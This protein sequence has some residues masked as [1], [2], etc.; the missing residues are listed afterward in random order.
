MKAKIDRQDVLLPYAPSGQY[1]YLI[2]AWI[3]GLHW[4]LGEPDVLASFRRETGNCWSSGRGIN[5]MI[6]EATG[7]DAEFIKQFAAWFNENVW[8]DPSAPM[9]EP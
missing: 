9:D 1:E 6:D 2:P 5:K 7:A 4:A 8:G 3:G